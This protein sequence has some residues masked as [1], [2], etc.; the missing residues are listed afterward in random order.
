[1]S[2]LRHDILKTGLFVALLL[3]SACSNQDVNSFTPAVSDSVMIELMIDMH[4]AEAHAEILNQPIDGL[5]DSILSHYQLSREDF[6]SNMAYYRENPDAFHKVYSEVLDK[7][8][9][10]RFE[11][12]GQ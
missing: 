10:E 12:G 8:S 2:A 3:C 9:E 4:L 6:E 5:Q 11:P 1:M 7:I